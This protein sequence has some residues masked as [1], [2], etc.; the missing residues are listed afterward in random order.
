MNQFPLTFNFFSKFPDW[1]KLSHFSRVSLFS[2]ASRK[3]MASVSSSH[4]IYGH[5]RTMA[6]SDRTS[7][8]PVPGMG[9]GPRELTSVCYVDV[10]TIQWEWEL[11]LYWE[12]GKWLNQAIFA[13]F[14]ITKKVHHIGISMCSVPCPISIL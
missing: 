11:Y 3:K 5:C 14:L 8:G 1:K 13:P 4:Y 9:P 7:T 2:S 6:Y 12:W 10:F